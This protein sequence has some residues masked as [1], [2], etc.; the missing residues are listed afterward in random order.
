MSDERDL[1]RAEAVEQIRR[2]ASDQTAMLCTFPEPGRMK[3]RPMA[4]LAIDPDGT[5]WFLSS[6]FSD[7][8]R[9]IEA[10]PTVQLV[11]SNPAKSEFLSVDGLATISRD[12]SKI[13]ALWTPIARNWF[14]DG[15]D[16]PGITLISV[17]PVSGYYW[18]TRNNR[19][20]Q[21]LK[22]AIGA[23]TGLALDDGIEGSLKV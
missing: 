15:R 21:L 2:I 23:V 11:Y 19:A 13:D 5:L 14:P 3:T 4:T 1:V 7:K 22:I 20:V 9:E 16:D 12:P 6:R 8:N 17:L 10:N 18:D